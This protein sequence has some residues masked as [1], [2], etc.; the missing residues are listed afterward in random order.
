[1][2]CKIANKDT[3]G[4]M[5]LRLVFYYRV[6]DKEKQHNQRFLT[7]NSLWKD[8]VESI[9]EEG[10]LFI[11]KIEVWRANHKNFC[12]R[13][14]CARKVNLI[15]TVCLCYLLTV[16]FCL[17]MW[18]QECLKEI[19]NACSKVDKALF[20]PPQSACKNL[21]FYSNCFLASL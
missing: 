19:P 8:E 7:L 3:F 15:S 21:I 17:W 13:L 11:R 5:I 6:K 16:P 2:L 10:Y 1:M 20:L 12:G 9:T 4:G 18:G 14:A